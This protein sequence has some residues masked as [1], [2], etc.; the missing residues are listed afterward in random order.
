MARIVKRGK[1]YQIRV[2]DG[3]TAKGKQNVK[4]M[5]WTPRPNMTDKQIEKELQKQAVLFEQ[6]CQGLSESADIKFETFA[7]QWFK[8]YAEPRL[9]VRTVD[10]Y[11]QYTARTYTAI[12]SLRLD[13]ITPRH[14]QSFI[15]NLQEP[16]INQK[17]GEKE[18]PK[19]LSPGTVRNYLSFIS[20]V[21]DYA[22]R[23]NML[24]DN[25]CSRVV[26]PPRNYKQRDCYTLEEAQKFLKFLQF[27]SLMYRVF[28]T[29]AIYGGFRKGE[30]LGLEW[31]DIDFD[32]CVV[33][34]NRTSLYSKSKGG[35]FT[36][37]TKTKGSL[38]SLKL[39]VSVFDLL[40]QYKVQ[41]AQ[42]RLKMGDRW[43]DTD[44]LFT[45][46]NGK[47]L[48]N[49]TPLKWLDDFF[50]RTGLRKVTIHS[51]R[52]LNASLLI[53]A[54]VDIKTVSATLGH[55]QVSTTLNIY[56]H[57]F[58]QAQAKASEAVADALKLDDKKQA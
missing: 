1:G 6:K 23:M 4:T 19:G 37:T 50:E 41:Q 39:P 20:T 51:F 47:P 15:N 52:H 43:I 58:A 25:P 21:F 42:D 48:G 16:G 30:L 28:F 46:E 3:Y 2:S 32:S 44:R 26:L 31:K 13:K 40:R 8:E 55:S 18:P 36:D 49:S 53:N 22:I 45:A 27:E 38:R 54:G 7:K 34:V 33:S 14:I 24:K 9:R 10:R 11:K 12:G 29:L 5:T 17:V 56:A 57:T 35:I